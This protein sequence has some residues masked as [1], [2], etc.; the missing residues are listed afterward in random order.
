MA[1]VELPV[2]HISQDPGLCG[3]ATAQ[4]ILHSQGLAG[5]TKAVQHQIFA[6][7][8]TNTTGKRPTKKKIK[9][10]DCQE[11]DTQ[12]CAKC[13]GDDTYTCWCTYPQA[14]ESTLNQR[15]LVVTQTTHANDL[16]AAARILDCIDLN[17]APAVL[18]EFGNH[19]VTVT[20]YETGTGPND[21]VLIGGR[22]VSDIYIRDP[23]LTDSIGVA[24]D[25]WLK[26]YLSPVVLCGDF[27]GLHVVI[28]RAQMAV[29][30]TTTASPTGAAPPA[31]APAAPTVLRTVRRRKK[32]QPRPTHRRRPQ[33]QRR[34]RG[35]R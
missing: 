10:Q 1:T 33:T 3:A 9:T 32:K 18:V 31:T 14:L 6:D 34:S 2:T 8:Q 16:D 30:S 22:W 15:G 25:S 4:M 21:A 12:E 23:S 11:W 28:G 35:K 24:I 13:A 26:D 5:A 27:V 17:L 29:V 7:I 19:W 20:G